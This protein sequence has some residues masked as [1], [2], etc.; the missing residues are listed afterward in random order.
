MKMKE[1]YKLCAE[2]ALVAL[3]T[4]EEGAWLDVAQHRSKMWIVIF[5]AK[6]SKQVTYIH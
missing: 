1:K 4:V 2:C 6:G 5:M 3:L